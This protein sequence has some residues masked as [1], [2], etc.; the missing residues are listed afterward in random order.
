MTLGE[1][2]KKAASEA[3]G[4]QEQEVSSLWDSIMSTIP[5]KFILDKELSDEEAKQLL[6]G[7]KKEKNGIKSWLMRGHRDFVLMHSEPKGR[8]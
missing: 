3:S 2:L 1:V 5:D 6:E 7:L 8:A 4:L